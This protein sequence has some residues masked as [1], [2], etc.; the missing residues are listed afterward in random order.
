M[1]IY[2][3]KGSPKWWATWNDQKGRRQRKS[4]GTDDKAIAQALAAKWQQDGFMEQ[5]FGV[6]PDVPFRDA[7]LRYAEERKRKNPDSY[8]GSLKYKLQLILDTFG[9]YM[10]TEIDA[11]MIRE[12]ANKQGAKVKEAS[13]LRNLAVLKAILNKAKNEGELVSVPVFPKGKMPKG[14]TR[15]LTQK[16]EHRL[17]NAAPERLR[18]L[19]AFALDTGGRRS[20]LFRLDWRYVDLPNGR[21]T[22]IE[23]K[24]G[25]DRS[26][27]LTERAR[28][29]LL[30][31]GPKDSGPVFTYNGKPL[32]DVKTAYDRARKK[33][34]LEDFRFHDLRHTFAS[35]L[36]QQ[37]LP[38]Y[39]VMH[40][41]GHKSL[42]MV[43]RYSHLAPEYQ[44]RAIA[45]LNRYGHNLGTL[46]IEV[47]EG[48]NPENQNPLIPQGVVMVEPIGIEPT[49]SSLR[50][51][52][53]PN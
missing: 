8:K 49:T 16:E 4:T 17:L 37:G 50:T 30:A 52:R 53:S 31:I 45:A 24:N 21:V 2:K 33:A 15:W 43:Q 3:R 25:E 23:T 34:G 18:L 22:F 14:R 44:E 27:R 41:T 10:L 46:G 36:V 40:M 29:I 26:I 19:I 28:Q 7:L 51:T 9:D 6:I 38:L 20:E 12:F 42:S 13:V 11:K 39:E 47:P 35:R 48:E 5:H 1:R 32:K